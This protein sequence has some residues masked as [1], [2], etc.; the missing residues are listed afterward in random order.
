M[1]KKKPAYKR[2]R[3]TWVINPKTRVK[4][5]KKIYLRGR[6]KKELHNEIA[7]LKK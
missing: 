1:K 6:S 2:V 5:S 7:R 3:K 4:K